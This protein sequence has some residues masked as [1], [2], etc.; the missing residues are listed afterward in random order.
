MR[1]GVTAWRA[2]QVVPRL[3]RS[4]SPAILARE[5]ERRLDTP[6][7]KT[8]S[9]DDRGAGWLIDRLFDIAENKDAPATAR[10]AAIDRIRGVTATCVAAL[11]PQLH[12]WLRDNR[13][14]DNDAAQRLTPIQ[15]ALQKKR[16]AEMAEAG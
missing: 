15:R 6:K 14:G 9:V 10:L 8:E 2:E 16:Q 7:L 11:H 3:L 12:E 1:I 13:R 5:I 4:F